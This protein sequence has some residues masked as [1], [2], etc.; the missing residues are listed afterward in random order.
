[1]GPKKDP[2]K[3]STDPEAAKQFREEHIARELFQ[4]EIS[5]QMPNLKRKLWTLTMRRLHYQV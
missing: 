1:M 4:S 2:S 3:G 5:T